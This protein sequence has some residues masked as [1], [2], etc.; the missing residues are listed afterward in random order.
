[1]IGAVYHP[2]AR[3]SQVRGGGVQERPPLI[4][5]PLLRIRQRRGMRSVEVDALLDRT[6]KADQ[7]DFSSPEAA[8]QIDGLKPAVLAPADFRRLVEEH[9][10]MAPPGR[11]I[12]DARR[13]KLRLAYTKAGGVS[14]LGGVVAPPSTVAGIDDV[15]VGDESPGI[16]D[17][18]P[19]D[20]RPRRTP[21]CFKVDL[22]V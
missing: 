8:G 16:V 1:M 14:E 18:D 12:E 7:Q 2:Y 4:D 10:V 6:V 15:G 11:R 9:G 13:D 19:S 17:C 5:R 22:P 20:L 21:R 3:A